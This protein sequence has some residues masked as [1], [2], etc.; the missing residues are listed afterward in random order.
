MLKNIQNQHNIKSLKIGDKI[1]V[2]IGPIAHGGHFVSRHN[3]QVIF[4]RHAITGEKAIVEITATSSKLAHGDAIQILKKSKHRVNP[5]CKYAT[6]GGCGGCDFQHINVEVQSRYKL[7]VV[8]EQFDRIAKIAVEPQLITVDPKD[9]LGWRTRFDFAISKNGKAGLYASKSKNVIELDECPIAI[10]PINKSTIFNAD[11][12]GTDRVRASVSSSSQ[13]NIS[14][15]KKTISGPKKLKE[16][17]NKNTYEIS[18]QSFWQSHTSAPKV[19]TDLAIDFM[20]LRKGDIVCDLYGG[21]GLFTLPIAEIVGNKG[22][23]HLVELSNHAIRDASKIFK[24]YKNVTIHKGMVDKKISNIS[25]IDT[26]LLD[27]P[28]TGAGKNTISKIVRKSPEK[29]VYISCDPASLARD[30]KY[31][32]ENGYILDKIKVIDLFPMTHHVESIV[33]FVLKKKV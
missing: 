33:R 16:T 30:S 14:R 1:E 8:K 23:V 3:N 22:H 24:N 2:E 15:G 7:D 21:I 25:N 20:K 26:I 29:I 17:V 5:N 12:E 10:E 19:L 28:R 11:W 9:G 27:P 31:L 4:V 13:L 32:Q 6:P 18:P